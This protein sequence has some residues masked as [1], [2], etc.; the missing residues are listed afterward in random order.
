MPPLEIILILS[1]AALANR[2]SDGDGYTNIVE[3]QAKTYPGDATSHPATGGDTTLPVVT[4]FTIPTTS[5]YTYC[6]DFRYL[7]PR[8]MSGVTG[9]LV[10]EISHKAAG[11]GNGLEHL[12]PLQLYLC[13]GRDQD[14]LCLGQGCGRE[15]LRQPER[16]GYCNLRRGHDNH[17][18][19]H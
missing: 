11:L 17:T 12:Y 10:N 8:I 2:D 13:H 4:G 3:I 19:H 1:L 5:S 6:A 9:Y 16:G 7:R 15:C 14:P 18:R